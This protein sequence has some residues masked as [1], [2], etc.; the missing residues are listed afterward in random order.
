VQNGNLEAVAK[1]LSLNCHI[2]AL[3]VRAANAY[4]G[5]MPGATILLHTSELLTLI[6]ALALAVTFECANGFHDT[7]NAVATVIYTRSLPPWLAVIWSGTWNFIGVL[8]S[9]GA[10]AFGIIGL[11]PADLVTNVGS[12]ISISMIFSLLLSALLWNVGTWY[13][14]IP[15]SST[16]SMVGAIMGVGLMNSLI[17]TG[18]FMGGVN[19]KQAENVGMALLLSP[20]VGGIGAA[21][22]FL[23]LK[24]L[25]RKPELYQPAEPGKTP[26]WWIRGILCLT[27]TGVSFAH[28]NNDGQKGLG[29]I[30]LI[31]A[32]I[33]PGFYAVNP[34]LNSMSPLAAGSQSAAAIIQ[35]YAGNVTVED[36]AATK[37]LEDFLKTDGV[38]SN[39]VFPALACKNQDISNTLAQHQT[40]SE[41]NEDERIALR[42]EMFLTSQTIAKLDTMKKFSTDQDATMMKYKSAL[43]K[44]I[45]FI[46]FWVKMMV[47][48]ALGVGTMIGW[49]RVVVTIGEKIGKAHLTY[50]QG[51]SAEMV[52]MITIGLASKYGL[53][54][55]TTHVLSSGVAGTM[56]A[57][58]SG[59]QRATL[60]N[61]VLAWVLTLPACI[62]LGAMFFAAALLLVF[63]IFHLH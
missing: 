31:L 63:H 46:P 20:L 3:A 51:A 13:F 27:C 56:A 40:L 37:T 18:S 9:T 62:F 34:G 50:A 45:K 33:I 2:G 29:L 7:A 61:I 5:P 47:A 11:L 43:D 22:L 17:N 25:V 4:L 32:G 48:F 6:F 26:P 41:L 35:S 58:N 24:L 54:V 28:G 55:S 49:K 14:G 23:L 8:V 57:N 59:L 60:R 21:L 30:M 1:P 39:K 42:A 36:G 53:P 44:A 16:H 19:W 12:A 15:V 52:A 10:V 38:F